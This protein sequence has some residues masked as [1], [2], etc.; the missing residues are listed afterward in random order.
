MGIIVGCQ[1]LSRVMDEL[2]SDLKGDYLFNFLDD[3]VV[4]S[5]SAAEHVGQVSDVLRR[6]QS[7][8]FTLNPDKVTFGVMETKYLG[9]RL[10]CRG[11][12]VLSDRVAAINNY[13]RPT[14]LRA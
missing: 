3:L 7:A 11:I 9:H 12:G 1:S 5:P 13:P 10:S 14:N 8:G 4:Y 6:L 2:F